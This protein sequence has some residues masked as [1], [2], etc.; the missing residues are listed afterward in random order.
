MRYST[1]TLA[2]KVGLSAVTVWKY[3][4]KGIITP[5]GKEGGWD[6]YNDS[7]VRAIKEYRRA[8]KEKR[9][10]QRL[11]REMKKKPAPDCTDTI[12]WQCIHTYGTACSWATAKIPVKGRAATPVKLVNYQGTSYKV[13]ECPNFEKELF[14]VVKDGTKRRVNTVPEMLKIR[15]ID[16]LDLYHRSKRFI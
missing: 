12:C 4:K 5:I 14:E 13:K 1:G 2:E 6:V 15:P 7:A 10:L 3:K 8:I 11:R 16:V 9:K